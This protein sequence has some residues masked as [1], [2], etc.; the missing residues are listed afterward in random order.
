MA[1]SKLVLAVAGAGKTYYIA[2]NLKTE[3]RNIVITFTNRN[4][5]NLE[6]EIEKQYGRVPDNTLIMTFSSFVYKWLIKPIEPFLVVGDVSGIKSKGLDLF[7]PLQK[8]RI[9]DK[10]NP[11]YYKKNH[12]RHYLTKGNKLYISRMADLF[13]V[14]KHS[15]KK[16][17]FDRLNKFCDVIYIDE[18]QDFV[19]NDYDILKQLFSLKA[20]FILSVGDFNQHSVSKSNFNTMRPFKKKKRDITKQEY[21]DGFGKKLIVD[22]VT[23][24]K[25]RRVPKNTCEFI[26]NKLNINIESQ[27][28]QEGG[29][30]LLTKVEDI[31]SKIIDPTIVKIVYNE[32]GKY[33]IEPITTWTYCKGDT[34]KYTCIILNGT[35]HDI[36]SD[37]FT[38]EGIAQQ[39]I[40]KLYVALSRSTHMTYMVKTK[41]FKKT[42]I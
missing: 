9:N 26:R 13:K 14:Q 27:S 31:K 5:Q 12:H 36:M 3:E 19:G 30:K 32:S 11:A 21:I 4:I 38:V 40:N 20:P 17:A 18:T 7:T 25:S 29:V 35:F 8:P 15:I 2:D 6:D 42:I 41:N 16:L 10:Y 23:L 28:K 39:E 24:L 34:F 1:N 22:K 33:D 37:D